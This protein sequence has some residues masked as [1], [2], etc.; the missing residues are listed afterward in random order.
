M[1]NSVCRLCESSSLEIV[2]DL[3]PSPYGDLFR[4]MRDS[5]TALRSI[6]LTL[7][8]CDRCELLQLAQEVDAQEIYRDY[9]YQTSVTAGLR[10]YYRRLAHNL[11][12]EIELKQSDLVIDVGS[13]DGT[14]LM[15]FRDVGMRV[16]GI[17]PSRNPAAVALKAGIP[18]INSFLDL[19]SVSAAR[20][21]HG[22]A[23]LV[24]A[25]YVA[26]NVPRPVEFF[27]SMRAMLSPDGAISVVTGY[28]PDQFAVRMFEYINHDHLSYFSVTS[29]LRLA[30]VSGLRLTSA[31]RVEHKGGSIH[32]L[33]H[34]ADSS[35]NPDESISK[36]VQ[37]ERWMNTGAHATY[38]ELAD[39]IEEVGCEIRELLALTPHQA[40][41]GI[42]ASISTT[43]L[44]HQFG[45]GQQ[46]E[47]LFD[48]DPNKFGKFSPG[49]GIEVSPL[50]TLGMEV[51]DLAI[52]LAW[53][54]TDVLLRRLKEVG[55]RGKVIVPLPNPRL[56]S[57]R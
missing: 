11:V 51:W 9:I 14:A 15:P 39:S 44:L 25:N 56:A 1:I 4:T 13:N 53:Q 50:E 22:T 40:L 34:Q 20:E 46:I 38:T 48:D 6:E 43:H 36:L 55:F 26:A 8:L 49:Y 45:I 17:E 33:F 19:A 35:I 5:A 52:I 7:L 23:K 42:G 28:H 24:C 10:D 16:L 12:N 27:K 30:E 54:H 29:A 47:K 2:W 31:E 18:T 32:L 57:Q 3:A 21:E 41:V 37:R